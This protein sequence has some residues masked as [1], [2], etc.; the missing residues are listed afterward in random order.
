[1][2]NTSI[3]Y[4]QDAIRFNIHTTISLSPPPSPGEQS[5]FP[6]PEPDTVRLQ[7]LYHIVCFSVWCLTSF[8]I[9]LLP[10]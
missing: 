4:A 6:V 1:M 8:G 9:P 3:M 7:K 2:Y 5:E 10:I